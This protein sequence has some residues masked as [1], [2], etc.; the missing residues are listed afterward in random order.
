MEVPIAKVRL[1]VLAFL[2]LVS[3][4]PA[5]ACHWF[6]IWHYPTRQ[7][8]P[9]AAS[10]V[11][12]PLPPALDNDIPLPDLTPV[13]GGDADDAT[14]ARLLLRAVQGEKSK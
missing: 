6:S 5:S 1:I 2:T 11:V 4:G 9:V 13:V 8:C 7:H 14:R 10:H 3:V 12:A